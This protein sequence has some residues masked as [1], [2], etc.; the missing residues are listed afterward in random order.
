MFSCF[1][2]F[3]SCPVVLCCPSDALSRYQLAPLYFVLLSSPSDGYA[4]VFGQ[5]GLPCGT[6]GRALVVLR[7]LVQQYLSCFCSL[8]T[9]NSPCETGV[10]SSV[11]QAAQKVHRFCRTISANHPQESGAVRLEMVT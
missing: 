11:S 3:L 5:E 1:F 8:L 2:F 6:L 4:G 10:C 9:I 7:P